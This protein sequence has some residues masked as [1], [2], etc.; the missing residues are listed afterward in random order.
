VEIIIN[1]K[2]LMDPLL[3]SEKNG[4]KIHLPFVILALKA[5]GS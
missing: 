1:A 2:G 4:I 5:G 3:G